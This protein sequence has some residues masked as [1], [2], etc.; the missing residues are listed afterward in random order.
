MDVV[1]VLA[2]LALYGATHWL[3]L[4]LSRLGSVE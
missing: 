3:I 2:L 1:F 4:A